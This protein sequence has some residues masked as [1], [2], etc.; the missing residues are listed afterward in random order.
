MT[1][2]VEDGRCDSNGKLTSYLYLYLKPLID[3]V[4]PRFAHIGT[5]GCK[6]FHQSSSNFIC[7]ICVLPIHKTGSDQY[8]WKVVDRDSIAIKSYHHVLSAYHSSPLNDDGRLF[9]S[10]KHAFERHKSVKPVKPLL[11][12]LITLR[13]NQSILEK[14]DIWCVLDYDSHERAYTFWVIQ[15]DGGFVQALRDIGDH[16]NAV[17]VSDQLWG[18]HGMKIFRLFFTHGFACQQVDISLTALAFGIEIRSKVTDLQPYD[19]TGLL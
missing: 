15:Q 10:V 6:I 16:T 9:T 11:I 18:K 4:L 2:G 8:L 5:K 14:L 3:S 1:T 13:R 12:L 17:E 19:T 7:R